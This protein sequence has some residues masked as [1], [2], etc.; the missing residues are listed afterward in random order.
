MTENS[1]IPSFPPSQVTRLSWNEALCVHCG[2]CV[3]QCLSRA[4]IVD[5]ATRRVVHDGDR[6]IACEL[7]IPAC[8]YGAV[9]SIGEHP[10]KPGEPL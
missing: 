4:F 9:E 2:A 10:G 6:C 1:A 7:C 5:E 3:G 8:S